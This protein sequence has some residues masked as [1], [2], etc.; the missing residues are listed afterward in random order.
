MVYPLTYNARFIETR[1][2]TYT[3]LFC[4]Y[5]GARGF[6]LYMR[7]G[8]SG[9]YMRVDWWSVREPSGIVTNNLIGKM[10][11]LKVS[12]PSVSGNV[13]INLNGQTASVAPSSANTNP[14]T[15]KL[16]YSA[17]GGAIYVKIYGIE[18]TTGENS[19][20]LV[21]CILSKNLTRYEAGSIAADGKTHTE[22]EVGLWD[23]KNNRF[24]VSGASTGSFTCELD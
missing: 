9:N 13:S 12:I 2:G 24:Y 3:N 18:L 6:R 15:A 1:K 4:G 17:D 20:T 16:F 21:P 23:I 8:N 14:A 11:D 22:G 10:C 5:D 19:A 7:N